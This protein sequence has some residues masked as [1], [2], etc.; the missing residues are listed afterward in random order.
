MVSRVEG[1]NFPAS[2][3]DDVP[4]S[5]RG[6]AKGM[7]MN[8][9]K[10]VLTVSVVAEASV[11]GHVNMLETTLIYFPSRVGEGVEGLRCQLDH[12]LTQ[13]MHN[14]AVLSTTK[15]LIG[16]NDISCDPPRRAKIKED[17][18]GYL[19]NG[20]A[21]HIGSMPVLDPSKVQSDLTRVDVLLEDDNVRVL[22]GLAP[23]SQGG[24][25]GLSL[26]SWSGKRQGEQEC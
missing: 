10:P 16:G 2:I 6:V 19:A 22:D 12:L 21:T 25:G 9:D 18:P 23:F 24:K 26:R 13:R 14:P 8:L 11:R 15:E 4:V 17:P 3:L 20:N 5:L 7:C 1:E